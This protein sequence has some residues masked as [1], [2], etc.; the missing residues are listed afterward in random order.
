MSRILTA[1]VAT[2]ALTTACK[3]STGDKG[4][5]AGK[6]IEQA[7][8]EVERGITQ[9]DATVAAL[10][11]LVEQPAPDLGPQFKAYTKS[12][13]QLESIAKSVASIS[14]KMDSKG[15]EY[16]TKWDEQIA[17]IQNEAIRER[18]SE[19]RQAVEASFQK[20]Q[21]EYAEARDEFKPL[22]A[23]LQDI[24]TV[25]ET[26]L[27]MEGLAA[28]KGDVKDIAKKSEPVKES[29][30]ELAKS[31]RDLGVKLSRS[32]PPAEQPAK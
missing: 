10:K 14:A 28:F 18:S 7:A 23:D 2:L 1:L 4:A 20:I 5:A 32:G 27:T 8:S 3:S 12:L 31:F 16:F 11:N 21:N 19:R 13:A 9:L 29:L 15:K 17:A 30:T 25:L 22:L 6:S 26:D 24:R